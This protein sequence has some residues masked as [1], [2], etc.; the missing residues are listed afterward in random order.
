[1]KSCC[2]VLI[3][4]FI[5]FSSVCHAKEKTI[6]VQMYSLRDDIKTL[7]VEKVLDSVAEM[8]YKTI[9]IAGYADGL[10]Y[11]FKPKEFKQ[12]ANAKGLKVTSSHMTGFFTDNP[13]ADI[14][15]WVD[16]IKDH[17]EIGVDYLVL[18]TLPW[19][20]KAVYSEADV[21]KVVN[22]FN[23][24]GEMARE[25]GLTFCFH[26]HNHAFNIK[27]GEKN[28]Y[29]ILLE[30]TDPKYVAMQMDVYWVDE[31]GYDPIDYL[32]RYKGRFPLLHIKDENV[33][34][35]SGKLDFKKIFKAAY[36]QG[37]QAFFVEVEHYKNTPMQDVK[38]SYEYLNNAK[39][40]K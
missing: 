11:G 10:I 5:C 39:F 29:T 28:L 4:I 12:L 18:S 31:A 20:G 26:N 25:N 19:W 7:G 37:M 36:K 14:D 24:I 9:E 2:K 35:D 15:R 33:I 38:E 23:Q 1:M 17:S 22:Y 30:R 3:F 40:V 21:D 6:G 8:G 13:Q 34:G 27:V 16:I 32:E